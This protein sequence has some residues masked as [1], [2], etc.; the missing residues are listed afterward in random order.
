MSALLIAGLVGVTAA[1]VPASAA[2]ADPAGLPTAGPATLPVYA[3]RSAGLTDKQVAALG[4]AL[5]VRKLSRSADGSVQYAAKTFLDVPT[6]TTGR[7]A[8]EDGNPTATTVLDTAKLRK[9]KPISAK[10]A[11]SKVKRALAAARLTPTGAQ[12][13]AG[14]T[15]L[16]TVDTNGRKGVSAALDTTVTYSFTLGD[17]PYVGPGAKIRVAFDAKGAVTGLNFSNRS[18][19]EVGAVA[20]PDAAGAL[21]RC[22][23]ATRGQI[24]VRTA[25][26]IYWA[27]ALSTRMMKLEPSFQCAGVDATGSASQIVVVPA[28]LDAVLPPPPATQ[29]P[30]PELPTPQARAFGRADVGSEG[31]GVCSGLDHTGTN[32]AAFN[33]GFSSRGI[34]VEFSWLDH[35][36]WE[37]DFKDAAFSGDDHNYTDHVDMTYWQGHGSPT[38]FSFSGCSS[39][40]DTKLANTDA[41]WGNGD[42]EWMSLFTC[43]VLEGESGGQAWWQ[44]W[45]N[46]FHGLHQ[47]N[48]FHTV[49]FHSSVHGGIYANYLLRSN[50][51]RVRSAW[52]QASIDDQPSSVLWASMGAIGP[53]GSVN[54]NDYFWGKGSVGPDIPAAQKTGYWYL[55]GTS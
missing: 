52:A 40:D 43:L 13:T 18:L 10:R 28:A 46:A 15:T 38:G 19:V 53:G 32:L 6:K 25:L 34:P 30:R 44:R 41:R 17:L 8:D 55:R 23:A 7:G 54:M 3:V 36:A 47:L 33:N 1:A 39:N 29:A 50:P 16:E 45:G 21:A 22:R 12:A 24:D 27:P 11:L 48:S 37:Q 26:P 9:L 42:V 31:T 49:S 5:G 14:N 35:N 2:A 20:V 51:L 4:K